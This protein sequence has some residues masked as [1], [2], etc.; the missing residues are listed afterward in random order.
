MGN[1]MTKNSQ[2]ITKIVHSIVSSNISYEHSLLMGYANLSALA[3]IIKKRLEKQGYR[4]TEE[5]IVSALKRYRSVKRYEEFD[6]FKVLSKSNITIITDALK[7]VFKN[8][9]AKEIIENSMSISDKI[10]HISKTSNAITLVTYGL[11]KAE[12]LKHFS[13]YR[14]QLLE[15]KDGLTLIV[16]HSP[17]EIL[18]TPGC[19]ELIYR[20][21]SSA[22]INIED[23][24][25]TYTDTLIVVKDEDA[26][27]AFEEISFLINY[28]KEKLRE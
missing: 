21:I 18:N 27:K 22:G 7:I 23:T 12:A 17:E 26:S 16:I 10:I 4:V 6:A 15:I 19:I 13:K 24:S 28:S 3:R 9:K 25:S 8:E 5:A 11:S 2:S 1:S 14:L 20:F